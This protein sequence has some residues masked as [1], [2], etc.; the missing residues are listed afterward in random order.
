M[1]KYLMTAATAIAL[2][3]TFISCTHDDI[4]TGNGK[5]NVVENYETAFISRFGQP[6]ANQDWGFGSSLTTDNPNDDAA[7]SGVS[8]GTAVYNTVTGI[9]DL[10]KK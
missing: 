6:G 1:K 9:L 10:I 4:T 8:G 2:C 7:A 3:G 5:I